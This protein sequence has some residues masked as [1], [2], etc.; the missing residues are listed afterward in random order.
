METLGSFEA[1]THLP[2]PPE[3]VARGERIAIARHDKPVAMLVPARPSEGRDARAIVDEFRACGAGG[4][5]SR[6][7][8]T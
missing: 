3:R 6:S 8:S 7:G 2:K 4:G 1:R 5:R